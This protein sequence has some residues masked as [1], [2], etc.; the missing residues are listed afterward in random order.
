ML[1]SIG[2]VNEADINNFL[3]DLASAAKACVEVVRLLGKIYSWVNKIDGAWA[4]V[5][6]WTERWQLGG[7]GWGEL[8]RG[9]KPQPVAPKG[10]P[11][12]KA[13]RDQMWRDALQPRVSPRASP[14]G[15]RS[16]A[17]NPAASSLA[18]RAVQPAIGKITLDVRTDRGVSV[19]S[20]GMQ[21]KN[22]DL[23]LIYRGGANM[24]YG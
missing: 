22:M 8:L 4:S 5:D 14:V 17:A 6:R 16:T 12:P 13:T 11:L 21:A 15:I 9:G 3:R 23:A 20:R 1:N 2:N 18:P 24:G 19:R 7:S 10:K